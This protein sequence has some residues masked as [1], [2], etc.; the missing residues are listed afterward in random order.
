MLNV[1]KKGLSVRYPEKCPATAV[2]MFEESL[3]TDVLCGYSMDF[4]ICDSKIRMDG[5]ISK[6][7]NVENKNYTN[8]ESWKQ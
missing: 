5:R 4:K 3:S 1:L 2:S 7:K 8:V 6:G